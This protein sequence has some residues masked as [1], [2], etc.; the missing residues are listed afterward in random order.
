[1]LLSKNQLDNAKSMVVQMLRMKKHIMRQQVAH[2]TL[3][4]LSLQIS[5]QAGACRCARGSAGERARGAL[6]PH[7]L[8][9][10]TRP[11]RPQPRL[12]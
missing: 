11:A 12:P 10:P 4:S 9:L 8:P 7:P 5:Q 2:A 1:M 3:N 6:S